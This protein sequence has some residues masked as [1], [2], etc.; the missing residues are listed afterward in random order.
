MGTPPYVTAPRT[1]A[2]LAGLAAV[3]TACGAGGSNIV[4]GRSPSPAVSPAAAA[5]PSGHPATSPTASGAGSPSPTRAPQPI[6][7]AY[8]VLYSNQ[9]VS[10]YTVSIVGI[11]GKV[12][13]SATASTPPAV[14]CGSA[15]AA[16]VSPPVSMSNTRAYFMD[17][18]GAVNYLAPSGDT[19]RATTLPASSASRRAMFAVSPD[20]QRIAVVV[21]DF[22]SSGAT[23][24]LYVEDVNGGGNH[25]DL[26]SENGASTLWPIGWHGTNNLVLAKV[27]SCTQ[28]GGP[29]CCGPLELHV[30]DPATAQRRFTLG[31]PDCVLAGPASLAGVVCEETGG[32]T[33]AREVNWTDGTFNSFPIQGPSPSFLAPDGAH[34][35]LV[36]NGQTRM[37]PVT[38]RY[39]DMQA[40]GWID[41]THLIAGGDLQ[42]QARVGDV[43]AGTMTPVAAQGDCAGR[44][45]G[46]L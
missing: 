14:T 6:T 13:A 23:T 36:V 17:A 42:T 27:V 12:A 11:D 39:M 30:I 41:G 24:H 31:G 10:T 5:S 29:F 21:D 33:F 9:A 16:L 3:L 25:L 7:G 37:N 28:G 19:G 38:I 44:L 40:C 18:Q 34:A 43:L 2:W 35:A 1:A 20:D 46:G 26:F 22:T 4:A 15:A 45:P 32:F 8:G